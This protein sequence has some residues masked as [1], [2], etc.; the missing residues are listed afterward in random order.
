MKTTLSKD[1]RHSLLVEEGDLQSLYDFVSLK[2]NEVE[3]AAKCIDGSKL[4]TKEIREITSFENPSYRK[5]KSISIHAR[6]DSDERMSLDIW[7]DRAFISAEFQIESQNDEQALYVSREILNRLA[8]V[9]PW[10]DLLTRVSISYVLYGLWFI[11]GMWNTVTQLMG[12]RPPSSVLAKYSTIE[13]LNFMLLIVIAAFVITYPF[14]RLQKYLF[15]KIFFLLGKQK[16]TMETIVKWR[17]FVFGGVVFA[18][19]IGVIANAISSW[20]LK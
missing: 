19:V 20:I 6:N 16:R 2:Y 8:E 3:A 10:Y 1:I 5:I 4:E 9:K 12:L 7:T 11:W 17:G 14:N 18:I 13:V 15:P